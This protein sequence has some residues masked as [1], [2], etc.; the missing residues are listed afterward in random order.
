[1]PGSGLRTSWRRATAVFGIV[2][3]LVA[4]L[5][6]LQPVAANATSSSD[7]ARPV[8]SCESL[9]LINFSD[10]SR[11]TS[12]AQVTA[13]STTPAYCGVT[14]LVPD[15]INIEVLLPTDDWN[16]RY[17][18]IGN[19]GYAGTLGRF[20]PAAGGLLTGSP[21]SGSEVVPAAVAQG[22]VVSSTDTGHQGDFMTGEW[23]WSP[24]GMNYAQ[25]Q[26]F[27]YRANHEM[28]VKSKALISAF[29]GQAPAYSYWN[30]CST[31]GR[32]GLT[33]AMRYPDDFDGILAG[34]PAINW[35][36][37]IPAEFWPQLTMMTLDNRVAPCKFDA[38]NEAVTHACDSNDGVIDG[39]Y[40]SRSCRFDP[41]TLIGQKTPCGTITAADAEVVK[42]IWQGP[43]RPDGSF[44]WYG[45]E[46][47]TD[48]GS[49]PALTLA[50][51]IAAPDGTA[52]DGVPFPITTEWLKWFIHKDP[53]WDWH[54]ETYPQYVKDFDQ[55]VSEW[56]DVLATNNPDLSAFKK[57]GG[58]VVIWHGMHDALIFP[59]GTIDY[60]QRVIDTMGGLGNTQQFAR[61]FLAP[62]VGH[63]SGGTGP[64]PV[65]PMS[66]VERWVEN[67]EAPDTL[68]ASLPPDTGVNKTTTTMT[69][70]L[71]PYPQA[72]R[73][74]GTGSTHN[75]EN[76]TC[77]Q[78]R[79]PR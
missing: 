69:R 50:H 20:L 62:H 59:R 73:Y 35:T 7:S 55:S 22:Y 66:A 21:T 46:P 49:T 44:M 29:Y 8:R 41:E 77:T 68:Q 63:C 34:A 36:K 14:L 10:G 67:G 3:T 31:G 5:V 12:A 76:F 47:G 9:A 25:I 48:M 24:T 32:E 11:V 74:T 16:G 70:P 38:V 28:A 72:A 45:Q 39:L 40:D 33:A 53:T 75:A 1:M 79:A 58:K 60:Y 19:G 42:N 30:G 56:A 18:A 2:A 71:C 78:Q 37:F 51:S 64:A 4:C 61:L 15:R 43:H 6:T 23:A 57:S 26:D 17:Q 65:D 54:T 27:A 13:T 52:I